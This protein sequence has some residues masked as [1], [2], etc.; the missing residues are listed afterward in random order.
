MS[1]RAWI[2]SKKPLLSS[3]ST[4]APTLQQQQQ[5]QQQQ[6]HIQQQ[7][8]HTGDRVQ[9]N[10][11]HGI[12]RFIGT[13]KFK[14]GT[15]AGIELDC[16][17]LGKNDGSVDGQ[18]Y[19]ICPPN[20]GL[21]ILA[22]KVLKQQ[23]HTPVYNRPLTPHRSNSSK[24]SSPLRVLPPLPKKVILSEDNELL[25]L[26]KRIDALEAENKMLKQ[27]NQSS[28]N[29]IQFLEQTV[30]EVKK[31][32]MD[33]IEILESM[34]TSERSKVKELQLEQNDLRLAGLE[35]IESYESTLNQLQSDNKKS[36]QSHHQQVQLF[37]QDINVL[38]NVLQNK[39][40]K[41]VDLVES[42]K[43]ERQN[44]SGHL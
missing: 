43:R 40:D 11:L 4:P 15:W 14:S 8:L 44:N 7:Q 38:E 41:Q 24:L 20:T 25:L 26:K 18:R 6:Q 35:A 19:F 23:H 36:Q 13:T 37:L 27:V 39:M 33:S 29:R 17:G 10:S 42:L 2:D 28:N 30:I 32:G 9:I 22:N 21:F 31:A 12:I 1:A 5:Q 3:R 34:V 16:V